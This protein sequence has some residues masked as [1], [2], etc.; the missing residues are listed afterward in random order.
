MIDFEFFYSELVSS[1]STQINYKLCQVFFYYSM[2]F[3]IGYLLCV[4]ILLLGLSSLLKLL[5]N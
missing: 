4:P 1:A 3:L 2:L 5:E